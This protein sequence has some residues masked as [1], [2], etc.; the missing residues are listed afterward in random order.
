MLYIENIPVGLLSSVVVVTSLYTPIEK[1]RRTSPNTMAKSEPISMYCKVVKLTGN[2]GVLEQALTKDIGNV[3]D[4]NTKIG[5][6]NFNNF[7]HFLFILKYLRINKTMGG[8]ST[9]K[10]NHS[11]TRVYIRVQT[12]L[13][14]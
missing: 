11:L 1:P 10:N 4:D 9:H 5:V 12:Y 7:F 3:I 8:V 2:V 6:A 13:T 14:C